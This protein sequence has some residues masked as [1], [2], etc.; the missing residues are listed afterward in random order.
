[1][2]SERKGDERPLEGGIQIYTKADECPSNESITTCACR[3]GQIKHIV[4]LLL[5]MKK[6]LWYRDK[7]EEGW[8]QT[9]V[10]EEGAGDRCPKIKK[11]NG[12]EKNL[13]KK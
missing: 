6:R 4:E 3:V 1:M 7:R 2:G 9:K 11:Q 12:R 10:K 13:Q 5:S 8:C